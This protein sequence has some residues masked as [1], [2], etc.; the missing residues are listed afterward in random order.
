MSFKQGQLITANMLNQVGA[1][2]YITKRYERT[3]HIDKKTRWN[4]KVLG[5]T[6]FYIKAGSGKARVNYYIKHYN[7][8]WILGSAQMKFKKKSGNTWTTLKSAYTSRDKRISGTWTCTG[9][10]W[11]RVEFMGV[12]MFKATWQWGVQNAITGHYLRYYS[13]LPYDST[14]DTSGTSL[15]ASI[16]NSGKVGTK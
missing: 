6:D 10:G 4:Y 12:G 1:S 5:G 2:K 9:E 11:Y 7:Y 14:Y 3:K 15:T 13:G 16:L 8:L